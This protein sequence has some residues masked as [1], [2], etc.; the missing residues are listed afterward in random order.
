MNR[1]SSETASPRRSHP[2]RDPRA[3]EAADTAWISRQVEAIAEARRNGR[4][5]PVED[6]LS[7][8]PELPD[9]TAIRLIYEDVCLRRDEGQEVVTEEVV[10]R[11]PR[12]Q[13]ELEILL[14]CDRLLRPHNGAV[15]W[16]EV[17]SDLGPYR[18]YAELG[19]AR[20]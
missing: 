19:V 1:P 8:H 12:W 9:E 10:G 2:A 17:G 14:G 11:F 3:T 16:P 13:A 20:D 15:A 4:K 18:L 6:V 5:T 7:G